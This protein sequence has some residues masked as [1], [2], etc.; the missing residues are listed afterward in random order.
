MIDNNNKKW[1]KVRC[2]KKPGK[3][4]LS[5]ILIFI[6]CN[7]F[8]YGANENAHLYV[9]GTVLEI[10]RCASAWLIKRYVDTNAKFD[11]LTD[12]QLLV[13]KGTPFDTPFSNLRRT[14]RLSTFESIKNTYNIHDKKVEL[15]A[16]LIHDIEINF[17]NKSVKEQAVKFI[18]E[19]KQIL[20]KA[21]DNKTAIEMSFN[22]LDN[23]NFENK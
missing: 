21:P 13:T 10:D 20:K 5:T 1:K 4:I 17:W 3:I 11:F 23:L 16:T 19:I 14:H 12:E 9:T 6:W 2:F 8:A 18:Y 22:Y 7:V 15:I